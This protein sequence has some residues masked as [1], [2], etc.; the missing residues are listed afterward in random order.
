MPSPLNAVDNENNSAAIPIKGGPKRKPITPE[1]AIP[2]IPIVGFSG[3]CMA[4]KTNNKGT[5]RE[6]PIPVIEKPVITPGIKGIFA[7]IRRPIAPI[8]IP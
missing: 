7:A 1:V 6:K 8:R 4:D 5:M 3:F 2:A